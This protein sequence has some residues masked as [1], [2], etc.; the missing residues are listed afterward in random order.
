MTTIDTHDLEAVQGG[1]L[2]SSTQTSLPKLPQLPL[3]PSTLPTLPQP[4]KTIPLG[5]FYP[6][7][8][9]NIA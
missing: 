3:P 8:P 4:P 1:T 2:S 7:T 6:P 5:P 9:S